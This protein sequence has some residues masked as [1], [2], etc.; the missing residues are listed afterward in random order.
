VFAPFA[1]V[2]PDADV[3]L[4]Q[5]S[6]KSGF[7]PADHLAAGRALAPLRDED[8]L[9]IGSGFSYHNLR[10][11]G[12]AAAEPS[13]QF[14][15]W[16]TAALVEASPDER[17]GLLHRWEAAPSV[18]L[19]HPAEDHLVPVMVAVGAAEGDAGRGSTTRTTSWAASPRRATASAETTAAQP[20]RL[21]S[22]D[23]HTA[24]SSSNGAVWAAVSRPNTIVWRSSVS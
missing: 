13:H 14:D 2:Y 3:P 21:V 17:T 9:I 18:R 7:D 5:L 11:F 22:S 1:V 19:A 6:F 24:R 15:A 20:V 10:L 4:V 23:S 16:L 12:A 8:V